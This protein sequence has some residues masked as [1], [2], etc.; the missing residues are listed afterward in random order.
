MHQFFFLDFL[1]DCFLYDLDG[2]IEV[3]SALFI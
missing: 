2:V 1:D 3:N